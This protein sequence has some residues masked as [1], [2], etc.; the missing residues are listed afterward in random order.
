MVDT[1]VAARV[2]SSVGR[3]GRVPSL[4]LLVVMAIVGIAAAAFTAWWRAAHVPTPSLVTG[5]LLLGSW[6]YVLCGLVAWRA[7]PWSWLG[8]VMW[9]TG[10]A[11]LIVPYQLPP[12]PLWRT[13]L[14]GWFGGLPILLLAWLILSYPSGRLSTWPRRL[15]VGFGALLV[16][17]FGFLFLG[18]FGREAAL[19]G[20]TLTFVAAGMGL[21]RYLTAAGATRRILTPVP[22][23][24]LVFALEA[25]RVTGYLLN[26]H[27]PTSGEVLGW[28][29]TGLHPLIPAAFLAGLLSARWARGGV[30][31]LVLELDG[32][33]EPGRLRDALARALRDPSLQVGYWVPSRQGYVDAGGGALELP[34]PRRGRAATV[35]QGDGEPLAVL[36][37][38]TAL[39]EER[40]LVDAVV[41]AAKLALANERLQAEVRA[42]LAEVQASRAR[43]VEAADAERR[44]VERNLHDGAQQRLVSLSLGLRMLQRRAAVEGELAE[45]IGEAAD[46]LKVAIDELRELARGIHP[47][48]LTEQGLGPALESLVEQTPIAVTLH[49]TLDGRLGDTVEATAY[50]VVA[51]SLTNVVKHG[52][53]TTATVTAGQDDST[54]VV[55]VSDD[56]R[57][58]AAPGAGRGL[59]GL[60]DRVA[61]IGGTL[62]V[63]SPPG[64]GTC[65]RAELPCG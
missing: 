34:D 54:L 32:V 22:F 24:S 11:V 42:Q 57:G 38:D 7:R 47:S 46:D 62:T 27:T 13:Y 40:D 65:V 60:A 31:N 10:L 33:P 14:A 52:R 3:P 20:Q 50:Y 35:V 26:V 15:L 8:P 25:A 12:P 17:P 53:A 55:E 49:T 58:G 43:I 18:P 61:A 4:P 29:A 56:G 9:A 21:H 5:L 2:S 64:E 37:H 19:V 63:A 44:R 16:L 1:A 51:E 6:S 39:T 30:G 28:I 48:I 41:A 45:E 23:A 36:V 59:S